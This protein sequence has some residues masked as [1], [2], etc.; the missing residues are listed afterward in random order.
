MWTVILTVIVGGHQ[1]APL[2]SPGDLPSRW[3]AEARA[4]TASNAL[5]MAP[6]CSGSKAK[7]REAGLGIV[8]LATVG[9]PPQWGCPSSH[10]LQLAARRCVTDTKN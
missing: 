10:T 9:R 7:V 4:H 8:E 5:C 3:R 1:V 2:A 6:I